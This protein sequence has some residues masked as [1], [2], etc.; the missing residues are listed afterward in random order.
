[1]RDNLL[2]IFLLC[3]SFLGS[4][5]RMMNC[6]KSKLLWSWSSAR[7]VDALRF[8][9]SA[10][11]ERELS[12]SFEN[13]FKYQSES[14]TQWVIIWMKYPNVC[15]LTGF[16]DH[17]WNSMCHILVKQTF[18]SAWTSHTE[19]SELFRYKERFC[20]PCPCEHSLLNRTVEGISTKVWFESETFYDESSFEIYFLNFKLLKF[21]W[22]VIYMLFCGTRCVIEICVVLLW[23]V[24]NHTYVCVQFENICF[25]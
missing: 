23:E 4:F 7:F 25:C 1:M 13:W 17:A 9:G 14:I 21:Y 8:L 11:D 22:N 20:F 10:K 12:A 16:W 6:F 5:L 3:W 24:W 19:V 18:I 2:H 15:F